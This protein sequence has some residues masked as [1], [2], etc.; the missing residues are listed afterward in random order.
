[1]LS[2]YK[3]QFYLTSKEGKIVWKALIT[4]E[5]FQGYEGYGNTPFEATQNCI[6]EI[7][8]QDQNWEVFAEVA[9]EF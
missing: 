4:N 6:K 5:R 1:M 8:E 9:N 7:S 3:L 2:D